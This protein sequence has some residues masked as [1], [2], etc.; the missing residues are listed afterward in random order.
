L[1]FVDSILESF[2]LMLIHSFFLVGL[3]T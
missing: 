2:V 1:K 3:N